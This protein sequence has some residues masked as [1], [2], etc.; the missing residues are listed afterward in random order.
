[1]SDQGYEKQEDEVHE[2]N[3]E[4]QNQEKDPESLNDEKDQSPEGK[5]IEMQPQISEPTPEKKADTPNEN[6]LSDQKFVDITQEE[7]KNEGFNTIDD[8]Q[9]HTD[10][11]EKRV[12]FHMGKTEED[13]NKLQIPCLLLAVVG[14]VGFLFVNVI[15]VFHQAES[16]DLSLLQTQ[17]QLIYSY[18]IKPPLTNI[19]TVNAIESCPSGYQ[20]QDLGIWPGLIKGC[21]CNDTGTLHSNGCPYACKDRQVIASQPPRIFT[22]WSSG[23]KLCVKRATKYVPNRHQCPAGFKTCFDSI[24]YAET[25]DCPQT[26]LFLNGQNITFYQPLIDIIL[27]LSENTLC[28]NEKFFNYTSNKIYPLEKYPSPGCGPY[29]TYNNMR[30]LASTSAFAL[31]QQNGIDVANLHPNETLKNE[32]YYLIGVFGLEYNQEIYCTEI[33]PALF[34]SWLGQYNRLRNAVGTIQLICALG[35]L[36]C[37]LMYAIIFFEHYK[38]TG[39]IKGVLENDFESSSVRLASDAM[40]LAIMP[41][42]S[43][44]ELISVLVLRAPL[45]RTY[46]LFKRLTDNLCFAQQDNFNAQ[47]EKYVNFYEEE[48]SSL[49]YLSISMLFISALMLALYLTSKKAGRGPYI[50]L[51][52]AARR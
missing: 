21:Y 8:S 6:V 45:N 2:A 7:S 13:A 1:M 41:A 39:S 35:T 5:D 31:F 38:N 22:N 4:D 46:N 15:S 29:D 37:L 26:N 50:S 24:C 16:S 30:S 47:L 51:N 42:L 11:N 49:Y 33:D 17:H 20:V 40:F 48:V 32:A 44:I 52:T 18:L 34:P 25:D 10:R 36:I 28:L 43:V 14:L 27:T 23:E 9:I 3:I 19:K 12:L